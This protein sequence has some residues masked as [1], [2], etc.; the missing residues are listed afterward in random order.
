MECDIH[1]RL[2]RR[3]KQD[4]IIIVK[5][6]ERNENGEIIQK[7]ISYINKADGWLNCFIISYDTTWGDRAYKMFAKLANVR[8]YWDIKPIEQRGFPEDATT[9]TVAKYG[10]K[11][12]DRD[13]TE[14]EE[15]SWSELGWIGETKAEK[16][17][18][19][20]GCE[21]IERNDRKYVVNPDW[22]SPNWCT[23][24]EMEKA[25]I[26]IFFKDGAWSSDSDE[27]LALLGAMIGYEQSGKY[28]CR[29]VF[30]FDN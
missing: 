11:I 2:E 30:W 8:N 14:D 27:W 10:D 12:L 20:Y 19:Q 26:E 13:P 6:E 9:S 22:H 1:L 21:V 25:I 3:L 28:E 17:I 29:A 5:P 18:T 23:T 15:D 24:R 7:E 4:E 16:W